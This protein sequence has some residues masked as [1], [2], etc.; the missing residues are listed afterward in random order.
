MSF[1]TKVTFRV[2]SEKLSLK[3]ICNILGEPSDGC[4][5]GDIYSKKGRKRE[6]TYWGLESKQSAMNTPDSHISEILSFKDYIPC[7]LKYL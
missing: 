2:Y 4:S 1:E 7:L 3:D 6:H 5:I